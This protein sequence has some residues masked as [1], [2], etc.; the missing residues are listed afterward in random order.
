MDQALC[1]FDVASTVKLRQYGYFA[2][3]IRPTETDQE[4]SAPRGHYR[5]KITKA[6]TFNN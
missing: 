5:R 3:L 1:R 2:R 4:N 6:S